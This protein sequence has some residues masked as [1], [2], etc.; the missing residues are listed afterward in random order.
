MINPVRA[1][2]KAGSS[3]EI[4]AMNVPLDVGVDG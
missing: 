1:A 3:R 2:D 4:L